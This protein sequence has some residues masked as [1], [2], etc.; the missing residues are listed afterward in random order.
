VFFRGYY[1]SLLSSV[2][3]LRERL[4]LARLSRLITSWHRSETDRDPIPAVNGRNGEC[5]VNEFDL[6]KVFA[7]GGK[8]F[9]GSVGF[10]NMGYGFAPGQCGSF[11]VVIERCFSQA[12]RDTNRCTVS[13]PANASLLC[14]SIQ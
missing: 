8:R 14:I 10:G 5:K 9:V 3:F 7:H 11:A 6:I 1:S 2:A 12:S 4:F 13:P